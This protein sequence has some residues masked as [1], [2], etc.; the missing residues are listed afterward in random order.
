[1][2]QEV[3]KNVNIHYFDQLH[4]I[5]ADIIQQI[6]AI[7]WQAG[8]FLMKRYETGNLDNQDVIIVLTT[9]ENQLI[10]FVALLKND[11]EKTPLPYAPF[12]STLY[13]SNNFRNQHFSNHLISLII[14]KAKQ[15]NYIKLY[16]MTEHVGLYEKFGFI[17]IDQTLDFQNRQMRI[18]KKSLQ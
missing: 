5:N 10:G 13:V 8:P 4:K 3:L 1:M 7:D 11:I 14:N 2:T 6:K 15:L 16:T 17:E 12:L 18:L 9:P